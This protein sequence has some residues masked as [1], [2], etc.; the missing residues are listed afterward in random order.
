MNNELLSV[1][2]YLERDRGVD[3]EI[4][5][6]AIESAIQQA[7]RRSL[8]V[9]NDIRIEIDRKTLNIRAYDTYAVSDEDTGVGILSVRKARALK[10]DAKAGDVIEVEVPTRRLGRI[11]AQAARQM[12]LQKIREAER[13]NVYDEY[14][15]RIGEFVSGTVRQV[16][17]R[18]LIIDL[19]KAEALLPAKERIPTEEYA[20]GDHIRAYV[21]RVQSGVNGPSIVLSRACPEFVKM[22]FRREVAEIADGII[23]VM[24]VARDPG[25]RSKIAV[26]TLDD[27]IDP[28]GAC[29]GVR[30]A[31][32]RNIIRELN[33]EKIDIV[34]WNSDIR[35]YVEQALLPAKLESVEVD[36]DAP[37]AVRVTVAPDQ[38][39]LAIGKHGQNVRLSSKLTNWRID[40]KKSGEPVPFE[41]RRTMAI[42]SLAEA[43]GVGKDVAG[44]LV[45]NGFLTTAG[46]VA[47]EPSYLQE[48]TGLDEKAVQGIWAAAQ[49]ITGKKTET[50]AEAGE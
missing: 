7:A 33:G 31:R 50:E 40:I 38:Y 9:T 3:R 30:G 10:P 42:D 22:L 20:V 27:K 21:H 37:R 32:V 24:S 39:S 28:V 14:K 13:K 23:E 17:H 35:Q 12:I 49:A 25:F 5:I 44:T 26:K 45:E 8:D 34:R 47:S 18:D 29:V 11:A 46:I 15:D 6:Q 4:I 48:V 1:V 36:P 2:S 41:E 43:L 19:G 16:V